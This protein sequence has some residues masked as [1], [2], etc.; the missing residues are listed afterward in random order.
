[1]PGRRPSLMRSKPFLT[2]IRFRSSS[3]T[4]S[5]TVPGRPDPEKSVSRSVGPGKE[6]FSAP[7]SRK[8][9]SDSGEDWRGP[10][11]E[12]GIEMTSLLEARAR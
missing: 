3:G 4:T 12:F 2:R 5:S 10:P 8:A 9:H 6:R 1:M 7:T 11:P